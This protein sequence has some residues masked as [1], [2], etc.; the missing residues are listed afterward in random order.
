MIKLE[1]SVGKTKII[2]FVKVALI[3]V[4][5]YYTNVDSS[6]SLLTKCILNKIFGKSFRF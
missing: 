4:R 2:V 5:T 3:R 1:N 6:I